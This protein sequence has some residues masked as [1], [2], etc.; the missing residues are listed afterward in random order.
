M[1][2]HMLFSGENVRK[3]CTNLPENRTV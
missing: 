3:T 2:I 1:N